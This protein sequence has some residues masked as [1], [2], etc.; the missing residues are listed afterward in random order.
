MLSNWLQP[1][2]TEQ[3]PAFQKLGS[4][5]FGK[6]ILMHANR[7]P[8]LKKAKVAIIG[9]EAAASDL[10]RG[11]LYQMAFPFKKY[12]I[13][14]LGN[15]RKSDNSFLIPLIHELLESNIVPIILTPHSHHTLALY[16]AYQN[17]KQ[18][19]NLA[20]VGDRLPLIPQGKRTDSYA[21]RI[22]HSRKPGL[23]NQALIAYQ[24]HYCAPALI[25]FFQ[26]RNW[27]TL[28]LGQ[29]RQALELA[30]PLIRDADI[31]SFSLSAIRQADA[32][33]QSSPSPS[34]L[35][36]EEA[37]QISRYAG[38]S[39]KLSSFIISG[40]RLANDPSL[41]SAEAIAQIIWYF[42]DGFFARH[43]DYPA[44]NEGL[45]EYVVNWK[46]SNNRLTFWKSTKSGRWWMQI[47][48]KIKK[49]QYRHR[50]VPC[51]YFDY[52]MACQ[53][54]LPDRLLNAWKRFA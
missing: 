53:D 27:D 36:L 18:L 19:L 12:Q 17:R 1:L 37:C 23:F 4:A 13:A 16:K 45:V 33:A 50:L 2:F 38:L 41:Q 22:V 43:N 34:G 21:N 3:I 47:P 8:S 5:H 28:R 52:Q 49:K 15:T 31:L 25:Q 54:D 11:A 14:D 29:M 44:S 51:S 40:Y 10:I 7:L 30:E 48:V 20:W 35:F 26:Q 42:L 32:P 46:H 39:N 24:T 6:N 9:I